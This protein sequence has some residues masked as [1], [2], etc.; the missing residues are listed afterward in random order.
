MNTAWTFFYTTQR[1]RGKKLYG[2]LHSS[3][4]S[5]FLVTLR[6]PPA[7]DMAPLLD[8]RC[9]ES[10][11]IGSNSAGLG[12][13]HRIGWH[14]CSSAPFRYDP[15]DLSVDEGEESGSPRSAIKNLNFSTVAGESMN[16][17][18]GGNA[19]STSRDSESATSITTRSGFSPDWMT[20][21]EEAAGQSAFPAP[22]YSSSSSGMIQQRVKLIRQAHTYVDIV[23]GGPAA[24]SSRISCVG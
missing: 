5:A 1:L 10:N 9:I 12:W 23:C 21:T 3:H 4:F 19:S 16:A 18:I 8:H 24:C 6:P 20:M 13:F 11:R 7:P 22:A 2:K 14:H 15:N 17:G